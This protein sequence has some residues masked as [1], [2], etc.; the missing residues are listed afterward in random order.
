MGGILALLILFTLVSKQEAGIDTVIQM[1]EDIGASV[2]GVLST[3]IFT[4]IIWYSNRTLG[5]IKQCKDDGLPSNT[6]I[7]SSYH[8]H[9]PRL[10]AINGIVIIQIG[11]LYL[12]PFYYDSLWIIFLYIVAQNI[13]YFLLVDIFNKNTSIGKIILFF[14]LMFFSIG[15]WFNIFSYSKIE[16]ILNSP[17][18]FKFW[19]PT[20]GFLLFVLQAYMIFLFTWRRKRIDRKILM[21]SAGMKG[22]RFITWISPNTCSRTK[23]FVAETKYFRLFN[24]IALLSAIALNLIVFSIRICDFI[25]PLSMVLLCVSILLGVVNFIIGASIKYSVSIFFFLFLFAVTIGFFF[26]PYNVRLE[27]SKHPSLLK[28][29]PSVNSYFKKWIIQRE[30]ILD[31]YSVENK[32]DVYLVTSDGG[33]SRAANWSSSVLSGLQDTTKGEFGKHLLCI[34]GASGGSVGNSAFYGLL[35]AQQQEKV[36]SSSK[37]SPHAYDY[38]KTDLFTYTLGRF[39]WLDIIRHIL[40]IAYFDD[41]AAAIEKVM[42]TYAK[43]DIVREYFNMNIEDVF[44]TSGSLPFLYINCTRVKDA[45]PSVI[46]TSKLPRY[47]QRV[48]LLDEICSSDYGKTVKLSTAANLSSRFPFLF[49]AG[50]INDKYYNDG[51]Y[52]DNSGAGIMLEF[53]QEIT[54]ILENK[55]DDTFFR[56]YPLDMFRF[57]LIHI[58]NSKI[59]DTS[60]IDYNMHPMV[61]DLF[62]PIL[63]LVGLQGASTEIR[64]GVLE[65]II[66][67]IHSEEHV[68]NY[69]LYN[70]FYSSD[71][72]ECSKEEPYPMSLVTSEY[73]LNRMKRRLKEEDSL[74]L[75]RINILTNLNTH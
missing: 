36:P 31:N 51:G 34:A 21:N 74:N 48:D 35:R 59:I 64:N 60:C 15:V 70:R 2:S 4:F 50:K 71:K 29:R 47:S 41:R 68:I 11:I 40:P 45:R 19:L 67:P 44:D 53:L 73:Q 65:T 46:S 12:P 16:N 24:L 61:N 6:K 69:S 5:Y 13:L 57:Q 30:N 66:D 8:K 62:T 33:G 49:P 18:R 32:F 27:N 3:T 55:S 9:F 72:L 14:L 26:N 58:Y 39:L 54:S 20:L 43:D 75:R 22:G 25:G 37:L 23:Y 56:K 7:P 38:F 1:G 17:D 52:F 63:T 42:N 28:E 10:L